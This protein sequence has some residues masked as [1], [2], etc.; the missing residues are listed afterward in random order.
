MSKPKELDADGNEISR[1]WLGR[2]V[3]REWCPRAIKEFNQKACTNAKIEKAVFEQFRSKYGLLSDKIH[4]NTDYSVPCIG[5]FWVVKGVK[6]KTLIYKH[7]LDVGW[8]NKDFEVAQKIAD[9]FNTQTEFYPWSYS[10]FID[11]ANI[12]VSVSSLIFQQK[13]PIWVTQKTVCCKASQH[14]KNSVSL[15]CVICHKK[16]NPLCSTLNLEQLESLL[17]ERRRIDQSQ[18]ASLITKR[19]LHQ[20]LNAWVKLSVVQMHRGLKLNDKGRRSLAGH[21]GNIRVYSGVSKT[22]LSTW[23]IDDRAAFASK[24]KVYGFRKS[25]FPPEGIEAM[26]KR[27]RALASRIT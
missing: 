6:I 11:G 13:S 5:G 26:K 7:Y 14:T 2:I 17:L 10:G 3:Y 24:A 12:E 19:A 18:N 22:E 8:C 27:A 16:Q 9:E 15:E 23:M 21:L 25:L 20:S 1:D 4:A